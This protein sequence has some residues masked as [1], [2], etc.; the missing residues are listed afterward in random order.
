MFRP[1]CCFSQSVRRVANT[2][3]FSRRLD[4]SRQGIA[5]QMEFAADSDVVL[6]AA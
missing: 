5:Y 1:M 6:G 2:R 4:E 3:I